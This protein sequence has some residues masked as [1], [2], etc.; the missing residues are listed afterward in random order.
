LTAV[1]GGASSRA[2]LQ[3]KA[4]ILQIP[5]ITLKN[6]QSGNMGLAILCA[7]AEGVYKDIGEAAGALV[8]TKEKI[9]PSR[10]YLAEYNEK[11]DFHSRMYSAGRM[12]Y[13][14]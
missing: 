9:Y 12:I 6:N 14:C 3:I 2:V 1:G 7:A 5:V 11:Y 4:D 13:N 10:K 8:K